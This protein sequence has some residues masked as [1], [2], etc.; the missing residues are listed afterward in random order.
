MSWAADDLTAIRK[1]LA[2]LEK[3]LGGKPAGTQ[4]PNQNG[5]KGRGRGGGRQPRD[6]SAGWYCMHCKKYNKVPNPLVFIASG[7]GLRQKL[8]ASR[9]R[10]NLPP[11]RLCH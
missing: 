7:H 4:Q 2:S 3:K 11:R 10:P 5:A 6:E 8:L 1:H 9:C